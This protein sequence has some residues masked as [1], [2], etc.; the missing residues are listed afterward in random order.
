M[1]SAALECLNSVEISSE[2]R[3]HARRHT[4]HRQLSVCSTSRNGGRRSWR[5]LRYRHELPAEDLR[6]WQRAVLMSDIKALVIPEVLVYYRIHQHALHSSRC[7]AFIKMYRIHQHVLH[8]VYYRIHPQVLVYYRIHQHQISP[9]DQSG[10]N[11]A[12][13][14]KM[15]GSGDFQ[16][17]LRLGILTVCTGRYWYNISNVTSN[18]I[19]SLPRKRSLPLYYGYPPHIESATKHPRPPHHS[20]SAPATPQGGKNQKTTWPGVLTTRTPKRC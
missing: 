5:P 10:M 2:A 20:H 11:S 7:I 1:A 4:A 6:L 3:E 19:S 8:S 15:E 17:S 9:L 14:K 13:H 16:D 18:V 12:W